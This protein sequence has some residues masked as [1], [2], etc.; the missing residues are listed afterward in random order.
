MIDQ[1][2]LL[3]WMAG[4]TMLAITVFVH[5]NTRYIP[6]YSREVLGDKLTL[7]VWEF[8]LMLAVALIPHINLALFICGAIGYSIHVYCQDITFD[9]NLLHTRVVRWI[10]TFLRKEL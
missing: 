1:E 9:S 3:W 7:Q 8:L 10:V 2:L 6:C 5:K 4:I